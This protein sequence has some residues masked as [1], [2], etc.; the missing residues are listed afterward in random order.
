MT[1]QLKEFRS[2][3]AE[4]AKNQVEFQDISKAVLETLAPG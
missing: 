1:I 4:V 3:I 2:I